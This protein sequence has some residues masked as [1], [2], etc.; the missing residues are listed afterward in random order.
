MGARA[1]LDS[2]PARPALVPRIFTCKFR[3][4][5]VAIFP[6]EDKDKAWGTRNDRQRKSEEDAGRQE[7][8][9]GWKQGPSNHQAGVNSVR[10][11]RRH[12][13][14]DV[15]SRVQGQAWQGE[16]PVGRDT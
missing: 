3:G 7:V 9:A 2:M 5:G 10:K 16:P 14:I 12:Q 11:N 15:S 6:R 13:E 4:S 8:K 1:E